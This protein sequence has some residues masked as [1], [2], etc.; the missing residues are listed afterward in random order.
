MVALLAKIEE[1]A[2]QSFGYFQYAMDQM[3]IDGDK[4]G[5]YCEMPSEEDVNVRYVVRFVEPRDEVPHATG[6]QC[7][8]RKY[9]DECKHMEIVNAYYV[10]I[11]DSMKLPIYDEVVE[12]DM[13][14]AEHFIDEE[15]KVYARDLRNWGIAELRR[16]IE[17]NGL[18]IKSQSKKSLIEALVNHRRATLTGET[19]SELPAKGQVIVCL[20]ECVDTL[21]SVC[22]G[23][24]KDDGMGC[25]GADAHPLR[26]FAR[27]T[28]W[29]DEEVMEV[30]ERLQKYSGSQLGGRVP[31]MEIV[32]S[33][34]GKSAE[35][36]RNEAPLNGNKGFNLLR[37]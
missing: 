29:K 9:R 4:H 23:A 32:H 5:A 30:A 35:Q 2:I 25:N 17:T 36:K 1:K 15:M 14:V 31:A 22:D 12:G 34:F 16:N 19:S 3:T 13:S 18:S 20:H 6:C 10:M 26:Y 28:E 21:L 37:V 11:Y 8:D 33:L 7:D 27:K 24:R